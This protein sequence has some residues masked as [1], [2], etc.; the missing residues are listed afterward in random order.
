MKLKDVYDIFVR[1]GIKAE[2]RKPKQVNQ[3][4]LGKKKEFKQLKSQHRKFFDKECLKNPYADLRLLHGDS[5]REVKR[6]LVGIDIDVGELLM[7]GID[8]A[9]RAWSKN[10]SLSAKPG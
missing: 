2:L 6:I 4:L 10:H 7:G 8:L 3:Y 9:F 1:E 5:N